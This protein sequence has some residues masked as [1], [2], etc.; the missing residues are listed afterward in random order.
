MVTTKLVTLTTDQ[1]VEERIEEVRLQFGRPE[2]LVID[3]KVEEFSIFQEEE[4]QT[5]V[6]LYAEDSPE[7]QGE[8]ELNFTLILN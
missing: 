5:E 4:D 7:H 2:T 1:E 8:Y 6:P 3:Y